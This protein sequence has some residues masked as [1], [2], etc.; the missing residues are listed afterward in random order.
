VG[1]VDVTASTD[2]DGSSSPYQW[3]FGDGSTATG[4]VVYHR[5]RG[6]NVLGRFDRADNGGATN[7]HANLGGRDARSGAGRSLHVLP[8]SPVVGTPVVFT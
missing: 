4:N 6:R 2:P 5:C 8:S 3:A 1:A 7:R